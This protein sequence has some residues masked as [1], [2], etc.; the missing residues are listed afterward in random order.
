[1]KTTKQLILG[2]LLSCISLLAIANEPF[3]S[4]ADDPLSQSSFL[5]VE[6]AYQLAIEINR[7][8]ST[9][10]LIWDIADHYYLYR[11]GFQFETSQQGQT[12]SLSAY[13][14]P[15]K[16]KQD[17]YFGLVQ[18]Y[19][20]QATAEIKTTPSLASHPFELTVTSQGCADAGLCYPPYA[21]TFTIDVNNGTATPVEPHSETGAG[22]ANAATPNSATALIES[23]N[24]I[25]YMMMLAAVGGII[26]NLMPCVFPVLS[27]KVLSFANDRQHSQASHGLIYSLG[28]VTSF[29][30]VAA[31]LVSLRAAGNAIGWGFH[32]QS[33]WFVAAL[34]YLFFVM[35]LN[36]SGVVNIG[37]QWM[38][39]GGKLT[40]A[41][42]YSGSF[43]TGVLATVV[44]S[45][46]TAPFMGTALGFAISQPTWIALLI[47]ASLGIGMAL[48]VL[49]LSC[50]PALLKFMP[51][52][53]VWM[54]NFKELLAFPLYATVI[55]LCWVVGNQAGATG[56]A[57]V[58]IGCLL[59]GLAIWLWSHHILRKGFSLASAI[60]AI[61]LLTSPLLTPTTAAIHKGN[62]L[63]YSPATL[64]ELRG[65][66]RSVFL[67]LTADWCITCLANE[68]ITLSRD[69][70]QQ[71][72]ADAD[73][74]YMKGDWTNQDPEITRLLQQ[75]QRSGI[76]LYL[77][78]PPSSGDEAIILPQVLTPEI[79]INA[80]RSS[81]NIALSSR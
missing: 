25:V 9:I 26:L 76:P 45:P 51:K 58:L 18:V 70:V 44:A 28:V 2:C 5:P 6:Q 15:G 42:G 30:A 54:E 14:P 43:F 56:M 33:P 73:I 80:I 55:W 50:S 81:Q 41:P 63:S 71:A 27:L 34:A 16:E 11:H 62:V 46:C 19:Y 66:G 57:M 37:G 4:A 7:Q 77:L 52:P 67:N 64:Q 49:I 21:Q 47:F 69:S 13:I 39:I 8:D 59:I 31:L 74:I 10:E 60:V 12:V 40:T 32:L 22:S 65:Q 29:I 35:A 48:P 3:T 72:F 75:Y 36:L 24:S 20:H 78:F 61:W 79:V 68:R 17:E 38:G 1:M 23:E 53:G